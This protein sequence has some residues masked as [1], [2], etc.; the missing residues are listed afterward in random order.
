RR[1]RY[2]EQMRR[3]FIGQWLDEC[4]VDES[5]DRDAG[6][7]TE[8]DHR[9][10]SDREGRVLA[11]LSEREAQILDR[12]FEEWNR[13]A[14]AVSFFC[15]IDA[16]QLHYGDASCFLRRH[17]GADVVVDMHLQVTLELVGELAFTRVFQKQ[18][19]ASQQPGAQF[20]DWSS[21]GSKNRATI[22]VVWFH[23]LVSLS[24]CLR[25]ERVSL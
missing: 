11:E 8:R 5:K 21:T 25:P 23:S 24:S 1:F 12:A 14:I 20:H 13:S 6:A 18:A 4:G 3:I 19:F 17:P 15:L 16:T 10:R 9:R 22:A 2:V 7:D